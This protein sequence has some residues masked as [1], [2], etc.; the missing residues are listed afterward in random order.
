MLKE[1]VQVLFHGHDHV[2]TDI[3]VDGIHYALTGNIRPSVWVHFCVPHM[4]FPFLQC[5][6]SP[7]PVAFRCDD[8]SGF[9]FLD[10]FPCVVVVASMSF[11]VFS[12]Y[13]FVSILFTGPLIST[14]CARKIW[15]RKGT[16]CAPWRFERETT[17][18]TKYWTT[19]GHTRVRVGT[20]L[21]RVEFVARNGSHPLTLRFS[22]SF[23]QHLLFFQ[24]F[25]FCS[26]LCDCFFPS[27]PLC[28]CALCVCSCVRCGMCIVLF[29]W[30]SVSGC[31][32][33]LISHQARCYIHSMW[34]QITQDCLTA[35]VLCMLRINFLAFEGDNRFCGICSN[36]WTSNRAWESWHC[37]LCCTC[38]RM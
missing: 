23:F 29:N 14:T 17:G 2:F 25:H 28:I 37:C 8:S 1:G 15:Q 6:I 30:N 7:A 9:P 26:I 11:C 22:P 38:I 34:N 10:L 20:A 24:R 19:S 21:A 5:L 16:T 13:A 4:G 27:L 3:V 35:H 33:L 31:R 32:K 18:Y 12:S 36:Y